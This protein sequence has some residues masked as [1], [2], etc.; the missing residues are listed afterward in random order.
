MA[1]S[2]FSSHTPITITLKYLLNMEKETSLRDII[3]V[4]GFYVERTIIMTHDL[5]FTLGDKIELIKPQFD[6]YLDK[7]FKEK[8]NEAIDKERECFYNISRVKGKNLT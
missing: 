8:I 3:P 7:K 4:E 1:F 5:Q 6:F 2:S